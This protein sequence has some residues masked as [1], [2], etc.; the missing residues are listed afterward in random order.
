[1]LIHFFVIAKEDVIIVTSQK[2]DNLKFD[3]KSHT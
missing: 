3:N 2:L 1:M